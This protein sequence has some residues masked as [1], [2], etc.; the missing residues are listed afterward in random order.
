MYFS[1]YFLKDC[2]SYNSK[3]TEMYAIWWNV[4]AHDYKQIFNFQKL[5]WI[6]LFSFNV[7]FNLIK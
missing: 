6:A 7:N 2:I 4:S 1:L 5:F 3:L